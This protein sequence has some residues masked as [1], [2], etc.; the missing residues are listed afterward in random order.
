MLIR[1]ILNK[2]ID[3]SPVSEYYP[4]K[5]QEI[6]MFQIQTLNKIAPEGLDLFPRET[7]EVASEFSDPDAIILRSYDLHSHTFQS[8]LKAVARAGAGVNNI[9][10]D[11]CSEKGIVVFNT[12][13]SNANSV[14][15][16]VFAGMFLASRNLF[17]AISWVQE[18]KGKSGVAKLVEKEK[19]KFKGTE[20]KGKTLGVIGLGAIGAQVAND[21]DAFGM[22]VIGCDPYISV[23]TAWN[24]SRTIERAK[25]VNHL[26]SVSDY[27]TIHVPLTDTNKGLINGDNFP[28][29]KK[30]AV[31]LNFSRGGLVDT[32][33]LKQALK[34]GAIGQ[35]VTDFPDDELLHLDRVIPLPHIGAST[36]E[37][38]ANSA[39]MAV[40]ELR[41]FL[42]TGNIANSVNYP[43][44]QMEMTGNTRIVIINKNI[45]NMVGQITTLLAEERINISDMLNKHKDDYA[46]TMIDV[47]TEIPDTLVTKIRNIEGIINVRIIG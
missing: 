25:N 6:F 11:A 19:S 14:K 13:G 30:G 9:P 33:G 10:I 39:I 12:P 36:A 44:C 4:K 3:I 34:D 41:E 43:S 23:D 17:P 18:Q 24:L 7:Y 37:A 28:T 27:I 42:E 35:Y 16:L 1:T 38:E 29:I 20:L 26:L 40:R 47:E 22:N 2:P 8:K 31:L 45:P 21:A 32:E 46:Y 15:E 5:Q